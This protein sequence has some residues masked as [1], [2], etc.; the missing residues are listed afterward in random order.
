MPGKIQKMI[1]TIIEVRSGGNPV[2][3]GS[4]KVKMIMKGIYPDK[5]TVNSE[6]DPIVMEK[7]IALAKE[8]NIKI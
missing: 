8:L 7:L 6:D 3:V 2:F 4:T 5:Y 1:D